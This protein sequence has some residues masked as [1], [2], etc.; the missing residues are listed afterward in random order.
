MSDKESLKDLE[1]ISLLYGTLTALLMEDKD[2]AVAL[3]KHLVERIENGNS[4]AVTDL[5]EL[6]LSFVEDLD[7]LGYIEDTYDLEED[8]TDE[9]VTDNLVEFDI[10]T[11]PDVDPKKRLN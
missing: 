4:I 10:K 7:E 11:F 5:V 3:L 6:T 8:S 9:L 1:T 2:D